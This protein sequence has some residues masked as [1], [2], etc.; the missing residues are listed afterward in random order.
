MAEPTV[1]ATPSAAA[2]AA[3]PSPLRAPARPAAEFKG[4]SHPALRLVLNDAD[5]ASVLAALELLLGDGDAFEWQP[6]VLDASRV[7]ECETLDLTALVE[8]LGAARLHPVA[9]AGAHSA[10]RAQADALRLG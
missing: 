6:V 10:L 1:A 5:A 8:R 4:L 3:H 2:D 7:S 9:L